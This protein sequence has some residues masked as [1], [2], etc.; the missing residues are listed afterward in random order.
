M[1][2]VV[3]VTLFAA[4]YRPPPDEERMPA[5]GAVLTGGIGAWHAV[6]P[7]MA[8]MVRCGKGNKTQLCARAWAH[9]SFLPVRWRVAA[10]AR[11]SAGPKSGLKSPSCLP[12]GRVALQSAVC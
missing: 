1:V 11:L 2:V 3:V 4:G 9:F 7:G 8:S 10:G 12:P 5:D 6:G